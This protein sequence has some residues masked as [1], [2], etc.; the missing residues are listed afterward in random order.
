MHTK[1]TFTMENRQ[2]NTDIW[3]TFEAVRKHRKHEKVTTET[4]KKIYIL[5]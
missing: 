4:S 3:N 2:Q 5:I 1:R